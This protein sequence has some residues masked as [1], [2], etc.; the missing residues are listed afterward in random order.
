M[1]LFTLIL[2]ISMILNNAAADFYPAV[3]PRLGATFSQQQCDYLG[4][5][6]KDAYEEITSMDFEYLRLGA[7]WSR[8]E[9]KE[10][11]YDFSELDRQLKIAFEKKIKILLTVGMK[12]PRWPEYYLPVW[13]KDR[14]LLHKG[15]NIDE[16]EEVRVQALKFI[17]AVVSRYRDDKVIYAWQ[18]ENEPF[19]RAGPLDLWIGKDFLAQEIAL[20]KELDSRKRPI[21]VNA[22]IISNVF[23]QFLSRFIYKSDP[24]EEVIEKAD[25]PAFNVYPVIGH[26]WWFLKFCF[27]SGPGRII[28]YMQSVALK[29]NRRGKKA[30]ITELQA[31]PWEPGK[32]IHRGKTSALICPLQSYTSLFRDLLPLGFDVVFLWGV[33]YWYYRKVCYKDS[34]WMKAMEKIIPEHPS[35]PAS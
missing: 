33:E 9:E 35:V 5:D 16:I 2:F 29:V 27:N 21:V 1:R 26:K 28:P 22:L 12:A 20:V 30:W 7:Y 15:M 14:I 17:R 19:N 25:I 11:I 8:I 31:E 6:W 23:L 32:L 24:V 13:L 18:V 34:S 4:I 10:G 3:K